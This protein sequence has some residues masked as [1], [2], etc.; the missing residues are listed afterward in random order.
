MSKTLLKAAR[1]KRSDFVL[2]QVAKHEAFF[3]K[4]GVD[5]NAPSLGNKSAYKHK[6]V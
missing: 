2:K 4:H 6:A 5:K 1:E 3:E